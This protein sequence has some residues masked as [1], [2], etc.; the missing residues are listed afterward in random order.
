MFDFSLDLSTKI[1]FGRDSLSKLGSEI[2]S[3]GK[4]PLLVYGGGSVKR[5]GL[6]D[7]VIEILKDQKLEVSEL[8]GV[9]PNPRIESVR[10]G[11]DI[12]RKNG[13]DSIIAMGGGSVLDAAKAIGVGVSYSGDVWDFYTGKAIPKETL[14]LVGILTMA[15]TGSEM[16]DCSVISDMSINRKLVLSSPLCRPKASFMDPAVTFSL[17]KKQTAAG[18]A[19]AF[20]HVMESYFSNVPSASLQT[21]YGEGTMN[22]LYNAAKVLMKTPDDYDARANVMWAST[23]AINGMLA[24]GNGVAWSMH[25]LE[26]ELS[27]YYDITHGV[28]LGIIIPAWMKW[29][30]NEKNA[31]RYK[32]YVRGVFFEDV[33][34]LSDM[35][36]AELAIEKTEEFMELLEMPRHLRDVGIEHDM[37]STMASNIPDKPNAF[38]PL[39]KKEYLEIYELAY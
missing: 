8:S 32:E 37:L 7:K 5:I 29:M 12:C 6:Y 30:L 18:I 28:G 38:R 35:E 22:T 19:D 25:P 10:E 14:P 20:S 9:S 31:W 23:W 13:C 3:L 2:S 1:V 24:A 21:R 11:I 16:S 36:A 39:S 15:G 34:S 26:H 27:A 17:P 33:S 4:K